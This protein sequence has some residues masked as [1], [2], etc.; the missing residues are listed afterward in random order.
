MYN[1]FIRSTG[2]VRAIDASLGGGVCLIDN[3][4]GKRRSSSTL[5]Q[6]NEIS[7]CSAFHRAV[8][9]ELSDLRE[10]EG[11]DPHI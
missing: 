10:R 8:E 9:P 5:Q 3:D 7:N 6:E 2:D 11:C 1:T 4:R